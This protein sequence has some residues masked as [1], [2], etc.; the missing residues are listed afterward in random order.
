MFE[1]R[2][3]W[4]CFIDQRALNDT[5]IGRWCVGVIYYSNTTNRSSVLQPADTPA[6]QL[7]CKALN[8]SF[9]AY[10]R[11]CLYWDKSE[12]TWSGEGCEVSSVFSSLKIV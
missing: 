10:P 5:A 7:P 1:E 11:A 8:Y 9:I 3:R 6:S 4:R 12:K 2:E